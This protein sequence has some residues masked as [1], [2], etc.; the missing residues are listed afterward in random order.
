MSDVDYSTVTVNGERLEL[1][2]MLSTPRERVPGLRLKRVP[3]GPLFAQILGALLFLAGL[4][5]ICAIAWGILAAVA[6]TMLT[7]GAASVVLGA[8]REANII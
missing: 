4:F 5:L 1:E 3:S 7:T 6:V 2:T 8:L